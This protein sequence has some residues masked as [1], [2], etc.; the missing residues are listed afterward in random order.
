MAVQ[1]LTER[2]QKTF[3]NKK[4][5]ETNPDQKPAWGNQRDDKNQTTGVHWGALVVPGTEGHDQ[6][7]KSSKN[8]KNDFGSTEKNLLEKYTHYSEQHR[9]GHG[10]AT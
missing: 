1:D 10:T 6:E 9:Q 5:L 8:A 3:S 2:T 4:V 7:R